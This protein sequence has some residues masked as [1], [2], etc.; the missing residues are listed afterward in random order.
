MQQ[1][2]VQWGAWEHW[3]RLLVGGVVAGGSGVAGIVLSCLAL[4][5]PL[6]PLWRR[7]LLGGVALEVLLISLLALA[8]LGVRWT[9]YAAASSGPPLA[10]SCGEATQGQL[11][12]PAARPRLSPMKTVR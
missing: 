5:R 3:W 7:V 4:M 10:P 12:P 11:I 8:F 9:A 6:L 2:A 1:Y